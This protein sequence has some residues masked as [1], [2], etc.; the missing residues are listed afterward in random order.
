MSTTTRI[1]AAVLTGLTCL[2]AQAQVDSC[3]QLAGKSQCFTFTYGIGGSNSYTATFGTDGSFTFPD[4]SGTAGTYTCYGAGL[5]DVNY[6]Y[7]GSETQSWYGVAGKKGKTLKGNGKAPA[8]GYMYSFTSVPGACAA[9]ATG[10]PGS[11]QDR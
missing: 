10:Q 2:A 9:E 3:T 8:S 5:T 1:A 6:A 7:A 4:V 11:R